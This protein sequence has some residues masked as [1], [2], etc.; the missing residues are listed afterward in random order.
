[1]KWYKEMCIKKDLLIDNFVKSNE[2]SIPERIYRKCKGEIIIQEKKKKVK[3]KYLSINLIN[4][5]SIAF[6]NKS[7]S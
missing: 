7:F 3:M 1:V 5:I 6:P 4:L 2:K